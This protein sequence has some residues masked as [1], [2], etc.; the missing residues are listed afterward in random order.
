M[1][2]RS[3]ERA[4]A[5]LLAAL[6]PLLAALLPMGCAV[7]AEGG[8]EA[9]ETQRRRM[10]AEQVRARGVTDRA[11]LG[12]MRRV[13]R[14][15]FVPEAER[16]DAYADR[17]LPIGWEQTISQPYVV[18]LMTDLLDLAPGDR[19]L[20]IGTGSG[21]QAAVLGEIAAEVYSIEIVGPLAERARATLERL[22]YRNVHVRAGDGYRGWP[23]AAPFDAILLTAAPPEIPGPLL[24][25]LAPGGRLVAPVGPS[26][27]VGTA[28]QDLLVLTKRPDG[29]VESRKVAPVRFVPMTGE[30]Q[31]RP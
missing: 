16:A 6:L 29:G 3:A 12:A 26:T 27:P 25:Q 13:P 30:A 4:A 2:R 17:P 28:W 23:E 10:V 24:D 11:V 7:A 19:V 22:G 14:D 9:V 5:R 21:Y 15:L 31:R 8:P 20:E 1:R 18:A